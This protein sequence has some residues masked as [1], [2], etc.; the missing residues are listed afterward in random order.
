M[1]FQPK[2]YRVEFPFCHQPPCQS[3][4]CPGI[5]SLWNLNNQLMLQQLQRGTLNTLC[6][7]LGQVEILRSFSKRMDLTVRKAK[8]VLN[9]DILP[10]RQGFHSLMQFRYYFLFDQNLL[11]IF[12]VQ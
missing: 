2:F 5:G 9:I 6:A 7:A 1:G 4:R 10:I 11:W 3:V 12:D 8:A